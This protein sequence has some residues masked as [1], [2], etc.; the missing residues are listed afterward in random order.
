MWEATVEACKK[1]NER[2]SSGTSNAKT[3]PSWG[4][5]IFN[6]M[7]IIMGVRSPFKE[8]LH[9]D[10]TA[11]Q[12]VR[13]FIDKFRIYSFV[14]LGF[15]C[16]MPIY[17]VINLS[18]TY[19]DAELI[20][21][22]SECLIPI[23]LVLACKYFSTSH[24]EQYYDVIKPLKGRKRAPTTNITDIYVDIRQQN[25][26][27]NVEFSFLIKQPCRITIRVVT[28]IVIVFSVVAFSGSMATTEF[29]DFQIP[30]IPFMI[31]SRLLGRAT[32]VNNTT[33][34]CYVFYKHVKVLNVYA[35]ILE[36]QRWSESRDHR[37]SILLVNLVKIKESLKISSDLLNTI[38]SSL[39]IIGSVIVGAFIHSTTIEQ[40]YTYEMIVIICSI[41]NFQVIFF[42]VIYRL[43]EAKS[44]IED[45]VFSSTF[46]SKFLSRSEDY[47]PD[48][49]ISELAT[50]QDWR[51]ITQILK[52]D[53]LDFCVMGLPLHSGVFIKQCLTVTSTLL[54]LANSGSA[55]FTTLFGD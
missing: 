22:L 15:Y 18:K 36:H 47:N 27:K 7:M 39:T 1:R 48:K 17:H 33:I 38:F 28:I 51:V 53:W 24:I 21:L 52:E 13:Y 9:V 46:A 34:F 32:V 19:S 11:A 10:A 37:C 40:R 25:K 55:N 45:V 23:Q 5:K 31:L 14:L 16:V 30:L 49:R 3:R 44:R 35:D 26:D 41:V 43:S 20:N 54:L 2:D 4:A 29:R 12:T 42:Y 6:R 50:T 8:L